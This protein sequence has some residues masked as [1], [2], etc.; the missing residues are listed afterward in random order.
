MTLGSGDRLHHAGR[1]FVRVSSVVAV[2][3]FVIVNAGNALLKG[4]DAE[5]FFDGGGRVLRGV[6]PY[7]GSSPASGFIGPPMQALFFAPFA[8][9]ADLSPVVARLL[10]YALN[11]GF[12]ALGIASWR[13]AARV[14]PRSERQQ[15][16]TVAI[17]LPLAA[18]LLPIQTNFEH[19]N[20]NALLLALTG[21]AVWLLCVGAA[22]AAGALIGV[23]T[24]LKVFPGLL[25]V[26]LIVRDQWRAAL[27]A[28]VTG[29]G[30]TLAPVLVTGP[31]LYRDELLRWLELSSSGWPIRN[32]NQSLL[33]A[34]DRFT[35]GW[36][37]IG[38]RSA[39][40]AP[41]ALTLFLAIALALLV[42]GV[43][44]IWQTRGEMRIPTETAAFTVLA[45]VLSPIAWDH[46]W[47][48][49]FPAFLLMYDRSRTRTAPA[50]QW[51]FW[52][53]AIL[54][55]GIS[56]VTVGREGWGIARQLSVST[57]A[58]LLLYVGLVVRSR[59]ATV[60]DR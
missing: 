41:L 51:I 45:V 16:A 21:G 4:G 5:V 8:A 17:L 26:Y 27:A 59:G 11:L 1:R 52:V 23:A 56:R 30:L 46:Y 57:I 37:A 43:R 2:A 19:Q 13:A 7:E 36:S 14:Q 55:S 47:V 31:A 58:A 49:M 50:D 10:W 15:G 53:A 39:S 38:V 42:L 48:L 40:D 35:G 60:E 24:A 25:I 9:L 29:A 3:V 22:I 34:L 18:T 32:N 12:L 44:M 20:M 33:A 6:S 54:T 28:V